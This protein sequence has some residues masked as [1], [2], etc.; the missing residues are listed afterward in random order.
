MGLNLAGRL[1]TEGDI[2]AT[3]PHFPLACHHSSH[4][5]ISWAASYDNC[6]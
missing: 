1:P 2:K 6:D 5:A 4:A 3:Q